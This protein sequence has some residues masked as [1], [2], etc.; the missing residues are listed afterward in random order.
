MVKFMGGIVQRFCRICL[1]PLFAVLFHHSLVGQVY[2]ESQKTHVIDPDV[3]NDTDRVTS[4]PR[5]YGVKADRYQFGAYVFGGKIEL[6]DEVVSTELRARQ[7]RKLVKLH[8]RLP[9]AIGRFLKSRDLAGRMTDDQFKA[10]LYFLDVR[11]LNKDS[12]YVLD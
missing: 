12:Y 6:P 1:I 2:H 3:M 5:K 10:L 11:Y 8:R 4:E 7:K 9:E